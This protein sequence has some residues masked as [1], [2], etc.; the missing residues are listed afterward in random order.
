ME[1]KVSRF[2]TLEA[3]GLSAIMLRSYIF[4]GP[5]GREYLWRLGLP[6]FGHGRRNSKAR[7]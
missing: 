1:W 5:D 7:A 2:S 4:M 6:A 3:Q